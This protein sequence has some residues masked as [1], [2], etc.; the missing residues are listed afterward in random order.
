MYKLCPSLVEIYMIDNI[1]T[2]METENA[3]C[4]IFLIFV[5]LLSS[6]NSF[7][8]YYNRMKIN[9]YFYENIHYVHPATL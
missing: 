2:V 6:D 8:A 7:R 1:K 4:F 5:V 9:T 3:I